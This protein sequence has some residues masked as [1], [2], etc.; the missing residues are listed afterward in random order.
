MRDA[1]VLREEDTL[2][3]E[4]LERLR[5]GRALVVGVLEPDRDELVVRC[6][7][8]LQDLQ[9]LTLAGH[10]GLGDERAI[11]VARVVVRDTHRA[12]GGRLERLGLDG[13]GGRQ[14]REEC[15]EHCKR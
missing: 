9:K 12:V 2:L 5:R 7:L 3:C 11:V 8:A 10:D 6:V 15:S 14:E 4:L 13:R 1:V